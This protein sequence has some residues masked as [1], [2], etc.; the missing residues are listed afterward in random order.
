MWQPSDFFFSQTKTQNQKT[1]SEFN[2]HLKYSGYLTV[3][4]DMVGIKVKTRG[5]SS[6]KTQNSEEY[7]NL[8]KIEQCASEI[9]DKK[10]KALFLRV[11]SEAAEVKVAPLRL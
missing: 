11:Q 4:I 7:P 2:T 6:T 9:T 3:G 8:S 10:E 1:N 5:S